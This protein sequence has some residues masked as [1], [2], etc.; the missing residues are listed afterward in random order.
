LVL[1]DARHRTEHAACSSGR[2]VVFADNS[3]AN[4]AF[5]LALEG[6]VP[7]LGAWKADRIA[8]VVPLS[9]VGKGRIARRC[10]NKAGWKVCHIEPVSDRK[11]RRVED[12]PFERVE[13]EFRRF[14]SPRNV[15]LIPKAISGAGELLEVIDAVADFERRLS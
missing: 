5:S 3:P 1:R 10:L 2:K 6:V 4:W 8:D 12:S 13:A 11:R 14:L 7:D 15:F 9:F